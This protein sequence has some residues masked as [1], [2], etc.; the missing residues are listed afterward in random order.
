MSPGLL[1]PW[2]FLWCSWTFWLLHNTSSLSSTGITEF[3]LMLCIC[4]H[5]LLFDASEAHGAS[6]TV[7]LQGSYWA[8]PSV[9]PWDSASE[10]KSYVK[11]H[12]WILRDLNIPLAPMDMTSRQNKHSNKGAKRCDDSHRLKD[13]YR[14]FLPNTKEFIF[15]APHRTSSKT[16]HILCHKASLNRYS[17]VEI[18]P[19]PL[20]ISY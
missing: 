20:C 15:S 4:F 19:P 1:I 7:I 12:P 8:L 5:Q 3:Y 16:E 13:I 2:V 6:L 9:W 10:L 11:S 14:I 18:T 17:K